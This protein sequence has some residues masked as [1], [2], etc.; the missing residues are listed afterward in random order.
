M[1]LHRVHPVRAGA[2]RAQPAGANGLDQVPRLGRWLRS[3]NRRS[4]Y[5]FSRLSQR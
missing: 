4:P 3:S 1:N 2:L 5:V